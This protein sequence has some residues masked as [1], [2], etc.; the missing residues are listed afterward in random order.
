V[1]R[2]NTPPA[3]LT[4]LVMASATPMA[5]VSAFLVGPA[6]HVIRRL[7]SRIAVV[8][9]HV[10]KASASASLV[11]VVRTVVKKNAP[12]NARAMASAL[13][14]RASAVPI[15]LVQIAQFVHAPTHVTCM[16]TVS[17]ACVSA[18]PAG[19]VRTAVSRNAPTNA[20]PTAVASIHHASVTLAGQ[21]THVMRIHA[22]RIVAVMVIVMARQACANAMMGTRA[23]IVA[24]LLNRPVN[25]DPLAFN[26]ACASVSPVLKKARWYSAH[27]MHTALSHARITVVAILTQPPWTHSRLRM[28]SVLSQTSQRTELCLQPPRRKSLLKQYL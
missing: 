1:M 3:P 19:K 18:S 5:N 21:A 11:T 20:M 4:A 17:E 22:H 6:L 7:V 15:T 16:A 25:V 23:R 8:L 24:W 14:A 27:A 9:V 10:W 28:A 12:T 26:S 13:T 2:A